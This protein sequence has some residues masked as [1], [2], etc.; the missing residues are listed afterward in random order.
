MLGAPEQPPAVPA[1]PDSPIVAPSPVS[2]APPVALATAPWTPPAPSVEEPV[3]SQP[4]VQPPAAAPGVAES[5]IQTRDIETEVRQALASY[6]EAYANL[7]AVAARSIWPGVDERA[8][9]RAFA[10]LKSQKL[11]FDRCDVDIRGT[12]ATASCLGRAVYVQRVGRQDPQ[13]ESRRWVF[14]LRQASNGWRIEQTEIR[15]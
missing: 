9:A 7:D 12:M 6:R 1:L 15:R 5:T 11:E 8:L 10:G 3:R 14:T 13:T 2:A 4:I